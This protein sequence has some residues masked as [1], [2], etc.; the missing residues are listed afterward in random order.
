MAYTLGIDVG[1]TTLKTVLLD[2]N[3]NILEKSYKRHFSK[4][5]EATLEHLKSLKDLLIDKKI[6]ICITGSAGLGISEAGGIDFVQEVFASSLAVDEKFPQT[7]VV[8][9]LGGEDA[10]IIF[11]SGG[12]EERMNGACAGGTGAFIDQMAN[13]MNL[14]T[15]EL[16]KLSFECEKLYP[17]ASRCGVFAKSDVQPLLNQGIRK[18][19]ICASIY[20]AVVEQTITGLAQGREIKG[21]VLFLGGPL[22]FLKGLGLR[23]KKSLNLDDEHA[24]FP[25]D[26]HY[27][28]ALGAAYYAREQKKEFEFEELIKILQNLPQK[29]QIEHE[30]AL[31]KNEEEYEEFKARHAKATIKKADINSYKG[32]AYLGIDSGSTTIKLLLLSENNE[33]LYKF[34]S[35]N[36]GNPV[37]IIKR[38]LQNLRKICG[39]RINIKF[40]AATGYGEELM[41]N[42]FG[43]DLGLV[44]TVAH[45]TAA[46]FFNPN[47]DYIIDIGG[48]DIKCFSIVDK[49]IDSVVLNEACSAGCGSFLESF[50]KSLGYDVKEFAKFA[51][52]AKHPAK[53]GTR[54][55]VF[56]NSSVKQAQKDGASIEDISAGLAI[57]V[58]K[59]AIYKV[60]RIKSVEELG[61]N[62]V[63]QGGTFLNDAVLRAFEKELKKDV[64]RLDISEMMGAFGAALFA[65]QRCK[66][67]TNLIT[68]QA[69]ENFK[70]E[71]RLSSCTK[72]TNK[73]ALTINTFGTKDKFIVGN[74]CERGAGKAIKNIL[75]NMVEF[76][77]NL[78][79][80]YAS[81]TKNSGLKIGI[82]LVLNMY[83]FMPFWKSFFENLGC[84]VVVS[85]MPNKNLRLK[86]AQNVPSDTVCY[87]AKISHS[88]IEYLLDKK[89]DII[90][91][92]CM[93]YGSNEG[94]S[95]NHF[96][97]P[98]VAYY[99]EL[100]G[101]NTKNTKETIF[102]YPHLGFD[103]I[104]FL[105]KRLYDELKN[106]IKGISISSVKNS[107]KFGFDEL[108]KFKNKIFEEGQKAIKYARENS[109]FS[110]V[111]ACQPYHIDRDINH[112]I[113]KLLN[114][115]GFV[116][117]LEDCISLK[118]AKTK[119][120]NQWT[121]HAKMYSTAEFVCN[122]KLCELVH[123]VSF[124]CGIDA[125]SADEVKRILTQ[126]GKFYTQIKI[127]EIAN[128]GA[129]KI[130]LRSLKAAMEDKLKNIGVI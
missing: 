22:H 51:I 39:D 130:R 65:K 102:L 121:Y 1:S 41:Q 106:H 78:L 92:P 47:V 54:C 100:L 17:I 77:N 15:M 122:E 127:D 56:M 62:V 49:K 57:S 66:E 104:K 21:N 13:L 115:L 108:A 48:Q 34:Y 96:N 91:Y 79:R 16:D 6:K 123:L 8:I 89:V 109:L 95:D 116:V 93:S 18:E 29:S 30:E 75:P 42:A 129:A 52:N 7:D 85:K 3:K 64:I 24:I 118:K 125:I 74:K 72:C 84:E 103:N 87:P 25:D 105:E 60:M 71:V 40:S 12:V 9:E 38:E 83:E 44:E 73:C 53:L 4:V 50:A 69:L 126:K 55:T 120:L 128:L 76:K 46:K 98:V 67:K 11:L 94:I 5:R 110:I 20:Q 99:P 31:F 107:I 90:F 80:E 70:H 58:I 10:K 61:K 117:L 63:V 59:N 88:H 82:P 27:F 97:C 23:F 19:D 28:V 112:S 33:L 26:G 45:Y 86:A 114:S 32:D 37:E 35:S 124:G 43:V 113:D 119:I 36:E 2:E 81:I 14:D 68:L 111:L 101:A